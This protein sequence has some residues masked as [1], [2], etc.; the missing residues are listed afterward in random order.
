MEERF[1]FRTPDSAARSF[2]CYAL[3]LTAVDARERGSVLHPVFI[4]QKGP[5]GQ[6][7]RI[8]MYT[9]SKV[10]SGA[11]NN[12]VIGV[13]LRYLLWLFAPF[14][15]SVLH[16]HPY[17][18]G[19]RAEDFSSGDEMVARLWGVDYMYLAS[20][21]GCL[22]K[23][24]GKGGT[25]NAK[26]VLILEKIYDNMPKVSEKINCRKSLPSKLTKIQS[27]QITKSNIVFQESLHKNV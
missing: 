21:S 25:R 4:K 13:I 15:I 8:K 6:K 1:L 17:C 16:T 27:I 11:H 19:H 14:K 20:P 24:N 23:Y 26:G 5:D 12:V 2:G 9:Y 22:Y 3:P 7:H 10:F 18:T